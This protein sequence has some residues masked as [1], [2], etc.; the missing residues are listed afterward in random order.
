MG[1]LKIRRMNEHDIE[2]VWEIERDLFAMPWSKASFLFE[3]GDNRNSYAVVGTHEDA[4]AGYA[5]AWFVGDEL[6]I[7]NVAVARQLQGKG[8]GKQLLE[9]LL[10]EA[11]KR[12]VK[13]AT[14]EVRVSN[15]RAI[16]LYRAYGFKAIALRRRYYTDSGE[17]ALVM[18]AEMGSGGVE[19][20]KRAGTDTH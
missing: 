20:M 9:H 4:I 14:L 11:F 19:G 1:L 3:A 8:A 17:D 5:V 16:N 10:D 2:E 7:G 18:L 13:H 12:D 15:V 6:H